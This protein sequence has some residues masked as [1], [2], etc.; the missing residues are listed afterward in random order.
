MLKIEKINKYFYKGQKKQIHVINNTSLDIEDK[1]LVALLGASGSGKT[2]LLNVIGGLDKVNKGKI[3]VN[4]KRITQRTSNY[5]DKVRNL[6]I[7]Y[8]FQDYK[9][10][11][12]MTVFENVALALKMIGIKD[13]KEIKKR[14][15]YV[16]EI[17]N[18][19]RYRNRPASMLSG[20]ERQRVGI[21]RA[22]VKEP[23]I[24]IADEPTGNLDSQNSIEIMNIIKAISKERLVILVTHEIEL[25]KF[26]ASRIIELKDGKIVNDYKNE[27][28]NTLDYRIDNK[29]Y[30][31]DFKN[32]KEIIKDNIEL[33]VY[34]DKN[35]KLNIS[36]VVK[37]G[38]I[39]IHN[40]GKDKLEVIDEE[41]NIELID[42]N[43]KKIDKD[44]YEDYKFNFDKIKSHKKLKYSS[45]LNPITMISSGFKKIK[46]YS[47][48]K[49]LLLLGFVISSMFIIYAVSSISATLRINE[50]DFIKTNKN[51]INVIMPK[52]DQ[53]KFNACEKIQE[54]DY[55]IP[56]DSNVTFEIKY[57]E[58]YQTLQV[59]DSL[60]GSLSSIKEINADDIIKGR[61]PE[62]DYEIVVDKMALEN[63]FKQ[64][65]FAKQAGILDIKDMIEHKA[66]IKNM[67]S[68]T[69]VGIV[70]KTSPSIY[71]SENVFINIIANSTG[72]NSVYGNFIEV[73]DV[74]SN[75]ETSAILDYNLVT[76]KITLEKGR[77]PENDYETIIDISNKDLMKIN[78]EISYLVNGKKLKVVGY[79][80]SRENMNNYLVNNNTI[81]YSLIN[82]KSDMM[83]YSKNKEIAIEK[84][85][86][87]N[88]N[89][90]DSYLY[91]K[92]K[93]IE[94]N[95]ETK[96]STI[97]VSSVMIAISLIEMFLM[98]RSS[99][100]S[101]IKE[102]GIYRAIG[103]KK[104]DI[105]KMFL[106]EIIA[107]TSTASLLGI[108]IMSY[109]L[110]ILTHISYFEAKY[111]VN[112]SVILISIILVF[113]FNVIIGLL[114]VFNTIRK[115]PAQILS[116]HDLD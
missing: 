2:T 21:A 23:N 28:D 81:K 72:N 64:N 6:N 103:V 62:N 85:R 9:L 108:I 30:L 5:I 60:S 7:G 88:L 102:V 14:V 114:P 11:D 17:L 48:L 3:Y 52:I 86:D 12:N 49:K 113:I 10:I 39:Y 51:Y 112:A 91:D 46:S 105:Y 80:S 35:E 100:L 73:K 97:I 43:Y 26:Y 61:L 19:Y 99:F 16:L 94:E 71:T 55:V 32:H 66:Y 69:I 13:K 70:D 75:E 77:Y 74:S 41:S 104:V 1:G 45:I 42:D 65:K 4:G 47:I 101:R 96:K 110:K 22:I 33:N 67:P 18:M 57:D 116:R 115:T 25:A 106:G 79:Y 98:I 107:I 76:D 20:G 58:Y 38:N 15:N 93:Y 109:I 84:L 40:N 87:L 95:R 34:S 92:A 24:I 54:I 53:E 59:I 78:K 68:F 36:L 90:K 82:N 37:N 44:I 89:V 29:I 63:M 56:G 111:V 31:K 8:I 50:E 83:V 27:H